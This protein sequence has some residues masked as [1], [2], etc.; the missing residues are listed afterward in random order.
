MHTFHSNALALLPLRCFPGLSNFREGS[1]KGA[2]DLCT[3]LVCALVLLGCGSL[4]PEHLAIIQ[5]RAPPAVHSRQCS[6]L[7]GSFVLSALGPGCATWPLS[8][9]C[10]DEAPKH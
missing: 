7:L 6:Q 1:E 5:P 2:C 4:I 8:P 10:R 9:Y 3:G